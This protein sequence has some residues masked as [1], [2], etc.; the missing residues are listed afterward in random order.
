[1]PVTARRF[2]RL[3]GVAN[4]VSGGQSAWRDSQSE[5][6]CAEAEAGNPQVAQE[7]SHSACGEGLMPE[8]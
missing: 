8:L 2:T 6:Y 5:Q 4:C 1:M 3:A 7:R